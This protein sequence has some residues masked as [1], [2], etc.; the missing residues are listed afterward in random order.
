M[1]KKTFESELPANY[2]EVMVIDASGKK[3]GIILNLIGFVICAVILVPA[4]FLIRPK[5]AD[6]S[7]SSS[8]LACGC[9]FLYLVLH[10]LTHGAA[11]KLLTHQKL[12]F[13]MTLT[14]A[15]CGVPQIYVYRTAAMISLLAPFVVFIPVFTVPIFLLQNSMDQFWCAVL[16]AVHVGGCIGDLWDTW[17]YLTRFRDPA[18]LMNDTGPKQTFYLPRSSGN[19]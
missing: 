16:L 6:Y 12:T 15:F 7:I 3:L 17:L 10:E 19:R 5:M 8:M 14:V 9:M 13:G 1:M 2:E 11:Y 4:F 18:V